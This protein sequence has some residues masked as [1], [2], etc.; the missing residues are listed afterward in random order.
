MFSAGR[1]CHIRLPRKASAR[2]ESA[3]SLDIIDSEFRRLRRGL[4]YRRSSAKNR[5]PLLCSGGSAHRL[6]VV[7]SHCGSMV[8]VSDQQRRADHRRSIMNR[9]TGIS[10]QVNSWLPQ[11]EFCMNSR[12]RLLKPPLMS[13]DSEVLVAPEAHEHR[14][15]HRPLEIGH[16]GSGTPQN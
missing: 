7:Q 16:A 5:V 15:L 4:K 6:I 13:N 9:A 12:K 11:S 3:G 1:Q 8:A 14:E 10:A 2:T